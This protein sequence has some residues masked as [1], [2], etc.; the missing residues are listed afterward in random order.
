MGIQ[1]KD[2]KSR[3]VKGVGDCPIAHSRPPIY[4]GRLRGKFYLQE[5]CFVVPNAFGT[6]RNDR[7][8]ALLLDLSLRT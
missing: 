8:M 6:P 5:D 7:K 3:R 2:D 4:I 1:D